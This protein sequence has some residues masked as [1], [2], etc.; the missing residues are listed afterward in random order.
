MGFFKKLSSM[1]SSAGPQDDSF[2]WFYVRCNRC[3]EKLRARV[4]FRNQVTPEYGNNDK[5]TGFY[6]RKV[7]MGE[8]PC[9]QQIEVKLKFNARHKLVDSQISGGEMISKEEFEQESE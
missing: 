8:G 5:A 1:F 6:C 4:D 2:Y 7:L 3:G 9:F